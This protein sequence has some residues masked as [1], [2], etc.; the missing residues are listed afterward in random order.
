[1]RC[2]IRFGLFVATIVA[3][4]SAGAAPTPEAKCESAKNAHAG[5]YAFCLQKAEGKLAATGDAARYA[6]EAEACDSAFGKRWVKAEAAAAKKGT[7]CPTQNDADAIGDLVAAHAA[8]VAAAL[9]S[10]GAL[11]TCGDGVVNAIDEHCDQ[12]DLGGATC[13]TL[14]HSSGVLACDASCRFDADDCGDPCTES[15]GVVAGGACWFL[16][17]SRASSCSAVC[18]AK[19]RTCNEAVTRDY[20]GSGGTTANCQA[21]ADLLAPA[22]S[23]HSGFD[24][25]SDSCGSFDVEVGVGCGRFVPVIPPYNLAMR[26]TIPATTCVA[27]GVGGSCD[28]AI[29]RICACN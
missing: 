18:V 24:E 3:G 20:A 23:P 21:L 17:P 1:M 16:A 4:A 22:T 25:N 5:L 19:G 10:G 7:T 27:D 11:P 6:V 2:A 15:G 26:V 9:A 29:Q 14:G 12:A 13:E 8:A 28:F